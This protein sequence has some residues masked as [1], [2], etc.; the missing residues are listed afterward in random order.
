MGKDLNSS[1]LDEDSQTA[2]KYLRTNLPSNQIHRNENTG[3]HFTQI[4]LEKGRS[5]MSNV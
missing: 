3:T 5:I 4:W 1:F 2:N